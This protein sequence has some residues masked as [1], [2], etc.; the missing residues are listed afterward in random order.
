[1]EAIALNR[2]GL[3]ANAAG[4]TRGACALFL[5]AT[6]LQ[7]AE[8]N[9]LLS[10]AN[11]LLKL[12]QAAQAMPMYQRV[13]EHQLPLANISER[14]ETMAR[15]KLAIAIAADLQNK[16][17]EAEAA[18]QREEVARA[19]AK[20]AA[21]ATL[22]LL[23]APQ[24]GYSGSSAAR[25]AEAGAAVMELEPTL[26]LPTSG[27][28]ADATMVLAA[29][30]SQG[31]G[32]PLAAHGERSTGGGVFKVDGKQRGVADHADAR[33]DDALRLDR[34]LGRGT[35]GTVWR[36]VCPGRGAVAVK[37]VGLSDQESARTDP[38]LKP[39]PH[40][41]VHP[42]PHPLGPHPQPSPS[43]SPSPAPTPPLS[44]LTSHRPPAPPRWSG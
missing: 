40:P 24:G 21:Q 35:Y 10:A 33:S 4:D 38:N 6:A 36:G 28:A 18:L 27:N 25:P 2:R 22:A 31:A 34:M 32:R 11:M 14:H 20:V 17:R 3:A 9:Y 42:H 16:Q 29:G 41:N 44:P 13:L 8:A 43:P 1:M 23:D 5:Q 30:A 39:N 15:D 12:G 19:A 26:A 37:I 7:P